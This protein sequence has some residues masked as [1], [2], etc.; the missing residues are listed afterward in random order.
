MRDW[1]RRFL[2]RNRRHPLIRK[3]GNNLCYY[4]QGFENQDYDPETNGERFVLEMLAKV[5]PTATVFDVGAHH[6]EWCQMATVAVPNGSIHSFEVIPSTFEK[7]KFACAS[8]PKVTPHLLG[9]GESDGVLEFSVAIG[10]DELSSGVAGVH[11]EMHQ[12]AFEKVHCKVMSG[13][14]FCHEHGISQVDCLKLDVE[15]LEPKVM[16]GFLPMVDKRQ[17]RMIQF[18]YGQINLQARFFLGDFYQLLA[19]RGMKL[20]K[21][22]PNYVDFKDYHFTQDNLSG[23]N[24]LAVD[25]NE[26][27]LIALLS[28]KAVS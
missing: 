21:I 13:T 27:R 14:S 26:E 5:Y 12:L 4:A 1:T 2:A 8:L 19:S 10:R 7:L 24:F 9:L 16:Q 20:G 11:G 23:P 25:A 18:E 6:G 3:I 17:I 28:G 15:G 22:Y